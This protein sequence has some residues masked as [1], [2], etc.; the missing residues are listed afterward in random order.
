[1]RQSRQSVAG[2]AMKL[3]LAIWAFT[4]LLFLAPQFAATG[5]VSTFSVGYV[6]VEMLF[7]TI[8]SLGLYRLAVRTRAAASWAKM[9]VVGSGV[10][11]A[12]LALSLFDA[13]FGG[14]ILK[15]FMGADRVPEDI[16]NMTVS[17]FISFSWLYGMLGSLY[18][19]LHTNAAV[20]ERD[21]RLLEAEGLVQ[22]AQ[23]TAL[24]LQLNPHFLFNT[25][26][27]ISSLIVTGRNNEGEAMLNKLCDF[28]R[29]AL[30]AD[31]EGSI[32]LGEELQTL[33]NYLEIEAVRFG[34]RLTVQF[35]CADSLLEVKVPSFILQP[36]VEN[37]I[38][39]GAASTS[40]PVTIC[41]SAERLEGDL[42]LEVSD[43]GGH[44][45]A[46][47]PPGTGLG[48]TNVRRRL[49]VLFGDQARL[50]T[51]TCADGFKAAIRLPMA[52]QPALGLVA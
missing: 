16:I 19:I 23:L 9:L 4:F 2:V 46:P 35:A 31:I 6:V 14:L 52:R 7:G 42:L 13:W 15:L 21:L 44:S 47:A 25:L 37:A 40:K 32:P 27:A 22:T 50:E 33:Q 8:L 34:D 43:D 5:R 3:T 18:V 51:V 10:C 20:R 1:M 39:Y 29:T 12:A 26:N 38:K 49:E 30:T 17:N 28:L 24:R 11:L 41:V 45:V 36:L 48:L